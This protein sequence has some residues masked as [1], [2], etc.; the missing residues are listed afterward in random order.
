MTID[1][2]CLAERARTASGLT[3]TTSAARAEKQ[4]V[5]PRRS[6]KT[7]EPF[8]IRH[9]CVKLICR[10]C[11]DL[12]HFSELAQVDE[13]VARHAE[14]RPVIERLRAQLLVEIDGPL[15]PI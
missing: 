15:I 4:N 3:S 7:S 2:S 12:W 1:L 6:A 14:H 9:L 8:F 11:G 13:R 10:R 5:T